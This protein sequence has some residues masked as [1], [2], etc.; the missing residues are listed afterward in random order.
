MGSFSLN[1]KR[2]NCGIFNIV[3]I[4]AVILTLSGS[5]GTLVSHSFF[6]PHQIA[7]PKVY[8]QY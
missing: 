7:I 3:V 4:I 1:I 2:N 5:I 6:Y 8:V